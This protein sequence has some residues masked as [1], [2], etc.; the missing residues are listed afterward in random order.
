VNQ[1][2]PIGE[3]MKVLEQIQELDLKVDELKKSKKSLP[4]TLKALDD[5]LS[6]QMAAVAAKQV[7]IIEIEKMQRQTQAAIELNKDRLERSS[8]RLEKVQNSHEFQ[9]AQKEL[10]QLRKL[11][12]QLQDQ[13]KRS[14]VEH[15]TGNAE[16]DALNTELAKVRDEREAHSSLLSG[17]GNKLDSEIGIFETDRSKLATQIDPRVLSQYNRIRVARGGVG[18]VLV[19]GGRCKGCNMMI[20]PQLYNEVQKA[21]SVQACP[22]CHRLLHVTASEDNKAPTGSA[23]A[24]H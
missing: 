14:A 9:A 24:S 3:Q 5:S 2:L 23:E 11:A 17:Q 16:L 6:R 15:V 4:L 10:D 22:S 12:L 8:T 1:P 7:A 19:V 21:V 13:V 20:P 18:L